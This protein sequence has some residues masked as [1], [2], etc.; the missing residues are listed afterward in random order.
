MFGCLDILSPPMLDATI[1]DGD[2]GCVNATI[3]CQRHKGREATELQLG[4]ISAVDYVLF[5]SFAVGNGVYRGSFSLYFPSLGY[6]PLS[7]LSA[8]CRIAWVFS[9]DARDAKRPS[10]IYV[11]RWAAAVGYVTFCWVLSFVFLREPSGELG[12]PSEFTFSLS[13]RRQGRQGS[14][15]ERTLDWIWA[16]AG[17][18]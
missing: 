11:H 3:R 10:Y 5:C 15:R 8:L 14:T 7:A 2:T 6:L 17:L 13:A 16:G 9:L 4:Y 1:R 18:G 12:S